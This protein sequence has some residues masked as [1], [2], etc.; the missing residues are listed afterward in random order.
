MKKGLEKEIEKIK[1]RNRK[2][3]I[4][5]RLYF[6]LKKLFLAESGIYLADFNKRLKKGF[7]IAEIKRDDKLSQNLYSMLRRGY[8]YRRLK[9]FGSKINNMPKTRLAEMI[10]LKNISYLCIVKHNIL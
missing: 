1:Q 4:D 9:I 5:K 6:K 7:E 8:I 3:E 2:V 10:G